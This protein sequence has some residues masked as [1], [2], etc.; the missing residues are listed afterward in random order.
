MGTLQSEMV[1]LLSYNLVLL[2]SF[3][4]DFPGIFLPLFEKK[5]ISRVSLRLCIYNQSTH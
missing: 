3:G 4:S 1:C 5:S 2:T